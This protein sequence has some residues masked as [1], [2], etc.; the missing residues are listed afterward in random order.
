MRTT[1]EG[2]QWLTVLC[3][4]YNRHMFTNTAPRHRTEHTQCIQ[5]THINEHDTETQ[6]TETQ[7]EMLPRGQQGTQLHKDDATPHERSHDD[8]DDKR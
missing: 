5:D 2:D 3:V 1:D 6:S 8:S 7:R 4:H